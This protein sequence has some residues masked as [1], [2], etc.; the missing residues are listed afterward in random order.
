MVNE[1]PSSLKRKRN[2][3]ELLLKKLITNYQ[4]VDKDSVGSEEAASSTQTPLI[5]E[6][7]KEKK[8]TK[9]D[10]VMVLNK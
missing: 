4:Y 2:N 1:D 5:K 3:I 9:N 10:D 7:K 6:S 8:D